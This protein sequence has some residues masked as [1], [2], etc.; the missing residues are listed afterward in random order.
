MSFLK[1]STK[2]CTNH[3][4]SWKQ[5]WY[6]SNCWSGGTS[7][8]LESRTLHANKKTFCPPLH[9]TY[10]LYHP[11]LLILD[12]VLLMTMLVLVIWKRPWSS[13][14]IIMVVEVVVD[15]LQNFN[16]ESIWSM[17]TLIIFASTRLMLLINHMSL[18]FSMILPHCNLSSS[19]LLRPASELLTLGDPN[20]N[21]DAPVVTPTQCL[22]T[23]TQGGVN[24]T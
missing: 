19:L 10:G 12:L 11:T 7:S 2:V 14:V 22:P 8:L 24:S 21:Q 6:S 17:V 1:V 23:H 16:V 13:L 18:F 3:L 4:C 15:A 9:Y 5:I 20:L